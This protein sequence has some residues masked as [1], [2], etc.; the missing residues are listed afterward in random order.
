M[1]VTA[2]NNSTVSNKNGTC[3][4]L[5][6][7]LFHDSSSQVLL[8]AVPLNSQRAV[9]AD[10][11]SPTKGSQDQDTP[12]SEV[13]IKGAGQQSDNVVIP[14]RKS[15]PWRV[16]KTVVRGLRNAARVVRLSL[17]FSPV[18]ILYVV[19]RLWP[20]SQ[21]DGVANWWW[22]LLV[23]ELERAGA[24]AIK[25]GQWASTRRDLFSDAF[26]D[27]MSRLHSDSKTHSLSHTKHM[28]EKTINLN[29]DE[30]FESFDP[31]PIGSGCV[32]QVH[33]AVLNKLI[34]KKFGFESADVV[35]KVLHPKVR[36]QIECDLDIMYTVAVVLNAFPGMKWFGLVNSVNQF[37][38]VMRQQ[39]DLSI[40]AN[41]LRRF[42]HNFE[43]YS[44][45]SFPEP[46]FPFI[47]NCVLVEEYI[48]GTPIS[49]YLGKGPLSEN[50]VNTV[51]AASVRK[52]LARTGLKAFMKMVLQ[53]NF[54]HGDLHP[55]NIIVRPPSASYPYVS[56]GFL[57]AGI[58]VELSEEDNR[59]F[60]SLFEAIAYG[61]GKH[62][63]Y[64]M[65]DN[66]EEED[67]DNPE[68]FALEIA[69]LV[70]IVHSST[71]CLR[72]V[73]VGEVLLNVLAQVRRHKVMIEANYTSL[74]MGI[75]VIEGIGRSLDPTL[76][77]IRQSL[78]ILAYEKI[79]R[80]LTNARVMVEESV[81]RAWRV[82]IQ[83]P[84]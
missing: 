63:G 64:L 55:G 79:K 25:F 39:L 62:A 19:A 43:G 13:E 71:L 54:V 49:D 7:C 44:A 21:S 27:H 75:V 20:W 35:V 66:A 61:H 33:K 18:A 6:D 34:V 28:I 84:E 47:S 78:P 12:G 48:S 23:W 17:Q 77:I 40:E 3:I 53:D 57:D 24:T 14:H 37:A 15:L 32:A 45:V 56:L 4:R 74:V 9:S 52:N 36:H 2:H 82:L 65:L 80:D 67:C 30:L 50:G 68:A 41:N 11:V 1:E 60:F 51:A 70:G 83:I 58:V 16:Y 10:N 76:D 72:E 81:Q 46:C 5:N 26:C 38:K 73:D 22:T 31:E 69:K 42:R 59:N 29:A 8:R